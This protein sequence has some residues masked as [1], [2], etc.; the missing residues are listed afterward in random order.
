MAE[1]TDGHELDDVAGVGSNSADNLVDIGIDSVTALATA[2][3]DDVADADGFG[4]SRAEDVIE[5]AASMLSASSDSTPESETEDSTDTES[6]DEDED[7]DE[8]EVSPPEEAENYSVELP[9]NR[10]AQLH[11]IHIVL[12]EALSRHK[13][14]MFAE[15]DTAYGVAEKLM[16]AVNDPTESN[17]VV[18]LE[19]EINLFF[20]AL[21]QGWQSYASEPG[22]NS[23]WADLK[24]FSEDVNAI[25]Q[26]E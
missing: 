5:S 12:E 2:T 21:N 24:D 15:R 11:T 22:V 16:R 9:D 17:T 25:R 13:S 10:Q 1:N 6:A 20:I 8:T 3:A 14:S 23:M 26:S 4:E 19:N 18:L 7:E